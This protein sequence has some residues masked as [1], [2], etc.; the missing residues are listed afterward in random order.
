MRYA[1]SR[2]PDR[3][4]VMTGSAE[5]HSA[6]MASLSVITRSSRFSRNELP[7]IRRRRGLLRRNGARACPRAPK[8][9]N[10]R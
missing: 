3:Q 2:C 10:V 6:A 9:A 5:E 7:R 1:P 8:G 4:G